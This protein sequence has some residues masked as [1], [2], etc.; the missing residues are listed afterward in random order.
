MNVI[1]HDLEKEQ[2]EILPFFA[3]ENTV[4]IADDKGIKNCIGCFSC[5]I[6]TPGQCI[7]KDKYQ[8]MGKILAGA[9]QVTVI[10]NLVYGG[11]SPFVKNVLD[12]SIPYLLPFF[13]TINNESHHKQ[14]YQN[15]FSLSVYFYG[16][17]IAAK[18]METAQALVKANCRNFYV[19]EHKVFFFQSLEQLS[20]ECVI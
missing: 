1:I 18:T 5:W 10:S 14:R 4:I 17:D 16:E 12:R 9:T 11:Y 3:G 13:R 2:F 19:K 7:I 20:R 15:T 8:E 6:K